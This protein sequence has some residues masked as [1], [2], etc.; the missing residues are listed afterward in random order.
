MTVQNQQPRPRG[1]PREYDPEV[2][3]H[4]AMEAFWD[5]GYAGTSM[6]DLGA[7]MGMNRP[8]LYAAFGDKEALYLKTL[9]GYL[10][11]R[12]ALVAPLLEPAPLREALRRTF[13]AM[14]DRFLMGEDGP[15]GCYVLAT[16]VTEAFARPEARRLLV[17]GQR[18]IDGIFRRAFLRA[19]KRGELGAQADPQALAMLAGS[20]SQTLALRARAGQPRQQ[21][22]ALADSA[23]EALCSM[24]AAPARERR[25]ARR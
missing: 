10:A 4:R 21:L 2:A 5:K 22:R 6:D 12:H 16:A 14:I 13:H 19:K 8:S 9:A 17:E 7:R 24:G 20:M 15:R 1:R 23:V 25:A 18:D 11:T 3:L